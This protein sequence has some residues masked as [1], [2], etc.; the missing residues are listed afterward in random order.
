MIGFVN[1]EVNEITSTDCG[2]YHHKC[3][4]LHKNNAY[5]EKKYFNL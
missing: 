2:P 5:I 4:C 1:G 3:V